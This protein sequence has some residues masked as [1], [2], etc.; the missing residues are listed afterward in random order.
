MLDVIQGM[1]LGCLLLLGMIVLR[2]FGRLAVARVFLLVL[3]AGSCMLLHSYV[4]ESWQWLT[5]DIMTTVPALFWLLCQLAFAHKPKFKSV[6]T[7]IAL[8][9]FLAPAIARPFGGSWPASEPLHL[10]GWLLPSYCE[11]LL[12]LHGLWVVA[13]NWQDDLVESRRQMRG[14]VIGGVGVAVMVIIVSM[15]TGLGGRL[16][17][18][19]VVLAC[20]L[21]TAYFLLHGRVGAL[22]GA[23]PPV[24]AELVTPTPPEPVLDKDVQRLRALM[25]D[26]FYRTEFLTLGLLAENLHL[27]E[28]KTRMLI[29]Q[30]MGY[31]NFNDYINQLRISEAC[32]RLLAEPQTP[33]LNI[34]LDVGYRTL[35]SF[36]RAFKDIQGCSPTAYREAHPDHKTA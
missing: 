19:L 10:F 5:S 12:T 23:T 11:Y 18:A 15:N 26:G 1:A 27:P 30:T 22:L 35:S 14:I 17:L 25:A 20:A 31:R 24:S 16:P 36:N 7:F 29:N 13:A 3:L 9:S 33:V 8:Y 34:S 4:P 32:R 28:Y 6:W 2:D 21:V